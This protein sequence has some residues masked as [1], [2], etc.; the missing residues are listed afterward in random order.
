MEQTISEEGRKMLLELADLLDNL[1][2]ERFCYGFWVGEDW[3]GSPDLSCG[4]SACAAGWATT[5]PSF[6]AKGLYLANY[7]PAY[8]TD[9]HTVYGEAAMAVVLGIRVSD[10]AH[11]FLPHSWHPRFDTYSPPPYA[12]PKLVAAH[13]RAW[14]ERV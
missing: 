12:G 14:L 7:A 3:E 10:A 4:T 13:I 8:R 11:L 9:D 2:K 5:L 6:R 1:P